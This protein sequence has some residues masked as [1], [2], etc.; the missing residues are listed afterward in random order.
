M[1][2][3]E[4]QEKYASY[5]LDEGNLIA[6][7]ATSTGKSLIAIKALDRL[8]DINPE[9][10][11]LLVVAETEH[12]NNWRK[13][14][15]K[16]LGEERTNT[17]LSNITVIC[18]AS[19][20]NYRN[21]E[22]D[23]LICDEGHH[24]MSDLRISVLRTI[25]AKRVLIL[26]ATL[27]KETVKTLESLFGRFNITRVSLQKSIDN[28]YVPKP[29]IHCIALEL[30]NKNPT[31][32]VEYNWGKK[33]RILADWSERFKFLK[34]KNRF[35]G[36]TIV[37]KCTQREKYDHICEK[38]NYWKNIY[39][40]NP[41][42]IGI[43]N[44]WL[45]LGSQRKRYLG[46]LKTKLVKP[47]LDSLRSS[48]IRF[49][50]FCTSIKQAEKLGGSS[51]VSSRNSKSFQVIEDFNMKRIDELFAVGMLTEGV[52]L[53]DIQ[54]GVIVQLDGNERLFLQKFGRSLR[55]ENPEQYIFYF[56]DTRDVEYLNKALKDINPKY[57]KYDRHSYQ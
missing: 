47:L 46:E 30:D 40:H 49:L 43:K 35:K 20:K 51:A 53:T 1:N 28:K 6:A 37:F 48:N 9:F 7:W 2:R 54:V 17:L 36:Y 3:D 14:F 57:V 12:K 27:N 18:Y 42:N 5:L 50:C 4:L 55:A 33:G 15:I 26:S 23:V 16:F 8:Y 13:E 52:S 41:G 45:Q 10:K 29:I 32:T 22:W 44:R 56:K 38:Y 25:K 24:I 39:M 19:L 34:E 11:A 21:T 31:E